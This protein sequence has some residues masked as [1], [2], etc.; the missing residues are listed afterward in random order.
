MNS[1]E[2]GISPDD[3]NF[4]NAPH[5]DR[6]G[7][8]RKVLGIV[9]MQLL[10]TAICTGLAISSPDFLQFAQEEFGIL[11]LTTFLALFTS[12]ALICSKTLSR[13]V[14]YNYLV[15]LIFVRFTQTLCESYGVAAISA[16][17]ETEDVI[18][19][20]VYAGVLTIVL[21]GYSYYVG[22]I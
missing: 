12:I 3:M 2:V 19:A 18:A 1:F 7:F 6:I 21:V 8:V 10:I 4:K 11:I 20:A 22:F 17:Y 14:P 13:T 15:L 16:M 9:G 5:E